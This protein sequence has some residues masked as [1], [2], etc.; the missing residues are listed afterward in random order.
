MLYVHMNSPGSP[1]KSHIPH[2][3]FLGFSPLLKNDENVHMTM[4]H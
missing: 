2:M 3:S 4:L 1:R